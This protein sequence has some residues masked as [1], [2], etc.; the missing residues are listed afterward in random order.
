[1]HKKLYIKFDLHCI[2]FD[3]EYGME[4]K[5]GQFLPQGEG[6]KIFK[7]NSHQRASVL[8]SGRQLMSAGVSLCPLTSADVRDSL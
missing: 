1:M 6:L 7:K 5:F 2:I 8:V 3:P 4:R